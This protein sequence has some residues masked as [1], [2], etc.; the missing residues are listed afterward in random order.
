MFIIPAAVS[1]ANDDA[2]A[3][4]SGGRVTAPL[5]TPTAASFGAQQ[6]CSI[7]QL[8][9]TRSA[10]GSLVCTGAIAAIPPL[11]PRKSA[12]D[13]IGSAGG[14]GAHWRGLLKRNWLLVATVS[15]VLL[16]RCQL[17][18]AFSSD[19]SVSW[20]SHLC[21]RFATIRLLSVLKCEI[22]LGN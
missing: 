6:R 11:L 5:Q 16:G 22:C 17:I 2:P 9:V 3:T 15:S 19:A 18:S 4:W 12:M 13:V 8:H 21:F 10:A 1:H 20:P 7:P 14:R